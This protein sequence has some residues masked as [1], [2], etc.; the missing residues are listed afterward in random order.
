MQPSTTNNEVAITTDGGDIWSYGSSENSAYTFGPTVNRHTTNG[1]SATDSY[2]FN[3]GVI[4]NQDVRTNSTKGY[5][6]TNHTGRPAAAPWKTI[7]WESGPNWWSGQ[8]EIM[9]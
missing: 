7:S 4:K 3:I 6:I 5:Y 2:A 9:I 1:G 8:Q